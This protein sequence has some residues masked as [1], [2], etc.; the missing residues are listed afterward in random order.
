MDIFR[1]AHVTG[2]RWRDLCDDALAQLGDL[3]GQGSLGFVYL[4]HQLAGHAGDILDYLRSHS[5]VQHWIGSLGMVI[6]ST[7]REEYDTPSMALLVT[8]LADDDFQLIPPIREDAGVFLHATRPWRE[9]HEAFFGI[10]HGDPANPAI[11]RLVEDLSHGLGAGYLVGGLTSSETEQLQFVDRPVSGGLSG[12][13]LSS[14]VPVVT[15]LSQGCSLIGSR[16]TVT[17]CQRNIILR[18][19]DRPALEVLKEEIGEILA[20][21][22]SRIGGY[23]FA[24]LPVAGSDTGDY[25]V[26]N[27]LGVDPNEGLIAIGDSVENGMAIRFA[28]RDAQ[29]A[30]D[31]LVRMVEE[32]T[33]RLEGRPLGAL[34]HSCLGRGRHLFGEASAELQLVQA[35]LGDVPLAGFYANGEI[36][37]DRLYGYTGVLTVFS[38]A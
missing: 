4:H 33:Q 31:D 1:H 17:E 22:L 34:Y 6:C 11:A 3:R 10:A 13:L 28:R 37:H 9:D 26:R 29:T 14:T 35:H 5:Q 2:S 7:G 24:A 16:H 27:L 32:V 15:G 12:V 18:I 20:R 19:D 30:R 21:D 25:L 8:G 23:I 36:Y 38:E